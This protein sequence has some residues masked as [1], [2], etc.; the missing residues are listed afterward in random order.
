MT[1]SLTERRPLSRDRIADAALAFIDEHGAAALSMRKL[2]AT[3]DVEAMSLYNHVRNKD[4]LLDAVCA[5]AYRE[6]LADYESSDS[7]GWEDDARSMALAWRRVAHRHPNAFD[8]VSGRPFAASDG[9]LVFAAC[10]GIFTKAGLPTRDAALAF[11]TAASW[12]VGSIRQEIGMM[13]ALER[14][15]GFG[16]DEVPPELAEVTEFQDACLSWSP[17]DRFEQ[18][19]AIMVAGV[20]ATFRV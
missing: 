9:I 10:Y 2:A 8:L 6:I 17:D 15:E 19:L 16:D 3:L 13:A 14:G 18:G 5:V 20:R 11:D 7:S 4:D 1:G 12:L